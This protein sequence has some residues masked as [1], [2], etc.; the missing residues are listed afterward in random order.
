[1]RRSAALA[2]LAGLALAA[3]LVASNDPAAIAATLQQA[4]WGVVLVVAL[5]WPQT[6]LSGMAWSRLVGGPPP[7]PD[8]VRAELVESRAR[9]TVAPDT[10]FDKLRANGGGLTVLRWVR[11]S[12]NALLPVAQ[13]GGDVVRARLLAQREVPL[14]NASASVIVDLSAEMLAQ[15][16]FTLAG[17]AA[18]VAQGG[19]RGVAVASVVGVGVLLGLFV[20]AQRFGGLRLLEHVV[21]KRAG[22]KWGVDLSGLHEA[23]VVLYRQPRRFGWATSEHLLSWFAGVAETY[24]GLWVLGIDASL[25]DALVIEALGQAV[26]AGGFLVPGALGV[27]EGGY[28]VV[29]ALV[30]VPAEQML[31]LSLL[32]RV[33][34]L[35]LGLPGLAWWRRLE[36]RRAA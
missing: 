9:G 32:R 17:V 33:R 5:H 7:G 34:E 28:V 24:A 18:L 22:G 20:G 23:V 29:G 31:A 1:V 35:A 16:V 2:L 6:W 30:G 26:R 15:V 10:P 12:V 4:G 19:G 13:V 21:A 25:G 36:L 27:Q 8:T 3:W 14:V 11:E